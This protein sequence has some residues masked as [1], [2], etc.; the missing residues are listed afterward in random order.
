MTAI[1]RC[2]L[3]PRSHPLVDS[4]SGQSLSAITV[5]SVHRAVVARACVRIVRRGSGS[6]VRFVGWRQCSCRT[7][8]H[9]IPSVVGSAGHRVASH[10]G[11]H[12]WTAT[13]WAFPSCLMRVAGRFVSRTAAFPHAQHPRTHLTYAVSAGAPERHHGLGDGLVTTRTLVEIALCRRGA[14]DSRGAWRG[15][16][17]GNP[18]CPKISQISCGPEST[19]PQSF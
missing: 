4:A 1:E 16:R 12:F 7:G 11:W 5:P 2:S 19:R 3:G 14:R 6:G 18:A 10:R 13:T 9:D 15:R 17:G 8:G